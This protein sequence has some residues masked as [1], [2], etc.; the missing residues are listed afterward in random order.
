MIYGEDT[1]AGSIS[2]HL[3]Y[4]DQTARFSVQDTGIGISRVDLERI[5]ERF[6][7][8][9]VSRPILTMPACF[10]ARFV[11]ILSNN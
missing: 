5:G 2:V 1:L 7:R 3:E 8:V 10:I 9:I 11:V 4:I 6:H